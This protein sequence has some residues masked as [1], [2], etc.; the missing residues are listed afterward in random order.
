MTTGAFGIVHSISGGHSIE[1]KFQ[2]MGIIPG[3]ALRKITGTGGPIV[4]EI[5]GSKIALG[6]GLAAKIMLIPNE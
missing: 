5:A 6:R 1:R 3:R 2:I 4:A